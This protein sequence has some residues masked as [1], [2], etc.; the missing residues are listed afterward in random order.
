[1]K[2]VFAHFKDNAK[3]LPLIAKFAADM[4]DDTTAEAIISKVQFAL[5]EE[6]AAAV[7]AE[8]DALK[9]KNAALLAKIAE[10][11][12]VAEGAAEMGKKLAATEAEF[13]TIKAE[14]GKLTARFGTKPVNTGV[15]GDTAPAPT[16]SRAEWNKLPHNEQ[17][18]FITKGGKLT[19]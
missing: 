13:S 1:M 11:S 6:E 18:A 16:M 4:A 17:G 2:A 15:K 7:V 14:Y 3:A 5:S 10:L 9:A 19:E 8:R 12:P